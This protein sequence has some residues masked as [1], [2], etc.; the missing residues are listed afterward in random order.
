M[1]SPK[2][3]AGSTQHRARPSVGLQGLSLDS[4]ESLSGALST[5]IKASSTSLTTFK[6]DQTNFKERQLKIEE[7]GTLD[8]ILEDLVCRSS[9][10]LIYIKICTYTF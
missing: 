6:L 7:R 4:R 5:D 10:T 1:A 9:L 3:Y 2:N 8:S